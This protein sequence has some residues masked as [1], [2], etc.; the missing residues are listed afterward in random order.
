MLKEDFDE[1]EE[2]FVQTEEEVEHEIERLRLALEVTYREILKLQKQMEETAGAEEAEIFETHLLI[3]QDTTIFDHVT[4]QVRDRKMRVDAPFYSYMQRQIQALRGKSDPYLRERFLDIKDVTQR[5]MRHLRGELLETPMFDHPVIIVAHDLTPSD[6]VQLD[7]RMVLA[8]AVET[9]SPV[10]HAAIIARSLGVPAVVR[11]TGI[12]E[13]LH[14]G[15]PVLLD[16]D[17]GVLTA[18]PSAEALSDLQARQVRAKERRQETDIARDKPAILKNGERV[19]VG[20]NAEFLDEV[21]MIQACGAEEVGLFRTEFLFL[22]RPD[23]EEGWQERA[24]REVMDGVAPRRVIFRTLDLGGDKVA[25]GMDAAAEPNPFLGWRGLRLSLGRPEMFRAQLRALLRAGAGRRL[26]LMFPM[27]TTV[28]EVVEARKRVD[29]C[30]AEL[31]QEGVPPPTELKVGAMIEVPGAAMV[32]AQLAQHVDFF[33]LGTNDLIQYT[34]A[35]DRLN[36]RVA[37]LYQPTHPAVLQLIHRVIQAGNAAG[38]PVGM[39][40]EMASDFRLVPLLLGLG[41]RDFSV[42]TAQV[43][44][45][46]QLIRLCDPAACAAL[47]ERVLQMDS[48]S[49][50]LTVTLEVA[51]EQFG[52]SAQV[53]AGSSRL[54]WQD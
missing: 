6:T 1:P 51:Q 25:S 7:R 37:D 33:S 47:A 38:I 19:T 36:E 16:G 32:A 17:R 35:V 31:S 23:A 40:G 21:P 34:L 45:L 30:L 9:G 26:G 24:Y 44:R 46:K 4:R 8:F 13:Q 18:F 10:S 5:V 15:D 14:S 39:C 50:V 27:V 52:R 41:L 42:A 29:A 53:A 48:A 2:E 22:A 43:A 20:C 28:E 11:L 49:E 3:I 54:M 12:S